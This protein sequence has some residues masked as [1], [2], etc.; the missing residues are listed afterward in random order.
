M[1][2]SGICVFSEQKESDEL[3]DESYLGPRSHQP[4][5]RSCYP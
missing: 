3:D 2:F 5:E 1:A 4:C